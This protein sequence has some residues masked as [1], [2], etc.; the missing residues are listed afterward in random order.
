LSDIT[1]EELQEMAK[2][3]ILSGRISATHEKNL[4]M[5][6]FIAFDGVRSVA[7]DYD[8]SRENVVNSRISYD[9]SI[10]DSVKDELALTKCK[11][12]ETWIR[13]LLWKDI[14]LRVSF[15][16]QLVYESVKDV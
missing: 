3:A 14:C 15:N 1:R 8:L 5:Y 12:I 7:I 6:P 13:D 2:L 11:H 9:I 10:D 16:G 4:K